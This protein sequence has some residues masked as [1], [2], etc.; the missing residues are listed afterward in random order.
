MF[1]KA[2]STIVHQDSSSCFVTVYMLIDHRHF[3]TS[4]IHRTMCRSTNIDKRQ[5]KLKR[6]QILQRKMHVCDLNDV[7]P[8]QEGQTNLSCSVNQTYP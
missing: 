1:L 4:V 3:E 6:G 7:D 8:C 5:C 2:P